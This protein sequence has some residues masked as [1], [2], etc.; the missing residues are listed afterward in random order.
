MSAFKLFL[1]ILFKLLIL[2]SNFSQLG[3]KKASAQPE[4]DL[5]HL[6]PVGFRV[7]IIILLL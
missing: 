3:Y 7:N 1:P 4:T 2:L 5:P 6:E